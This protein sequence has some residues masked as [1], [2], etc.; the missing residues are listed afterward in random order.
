MRIQTRLK[1]DWSLPIARAILGLSIVFCL[2]GYAPATDTKSKAKSPDAGTNL[3]L[4]EFLDNHCLDCHS[5]GDEFSIEHF[6]ESP[7]VAGKLDGAGE[8]EQVLLK[9]TSR[10]MPPLDET[11]RPTELEYD[12]VTKALRGLLA[13]H[14]RLSPR[15]GSTESLRRLTR[16]EYQNAVRDL[17]AV[18]IDATKLLPPDQ[19][20]GGFDNITVGDLS[21][22]RV[23]RLLAAAEKIS[24][25]AV[26]VVGSQPRSEVF[27]VPADVTQKAR[28]PGMPL[29]TRGGLIVDY[30][31]PRTGKYRVELRLARD[32]NEHVEGMRGEHRLEVLLDRKPTASFTVRPP[33]DGDHSQVD[34]GLTAEIDVEAGNRQLAVTFVDKGAALLETMRQPLQSRF[35]YHRHPRQNP[36]LYEVAI[37][38]PVGGEVPLAEEKSESR[39][40]I[41]AGIPVGDQRSRAANVFARLCRNAYRRPVNEKDLVRPLAFYDSAIESGGSFDEAIQAGLSCIL[42]SPHFLLRVERRANEEAGAQRITDLELASRLSFFLWSSLPDEQLLNLAE[43]NQLSQPEVLSKQVHRM[44]AD[45][46]S[47]SLTTNFA[48]QWLYLK[49]LSSFTPDA[50]RF[51]DFDENLRRAFRRETEL[52]F[53]WVV[54]E[55]RSV[56]DLF[57][58]DFTFLNE[59]LA[60]HY[61]IPGVYGSHFRRVSLTGDTLR[62]GLLRHASI[63]TITS[64]PTRTSPV[65]RGNWILKNLL[66]TPPPPPPED[67]PPLEDNTVSA[68]LPLRERLAAHR[69]NDACA[70]CHRLMDPI[71]FALENYDA[72]GRWREMEGRNPINTSGKLPDGSE[73]DGV[74]GL[75]AA[76][77]G[78]PEQFVETLTR[79]LATYAVGRPME[80]FDSPMIRQIVSDAEQA[81]YSFESL[82][83][84]IV[85]SDIFQMRGSG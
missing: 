9:L 35:N 23:T 79:K 34:A 25:L 27:R 33:A 44:L 74:G 57:A 38:G 69:D 64:Y 36:A 55:N 16:F 8:L 45:P 11:T 56:L 82:V 71:G 15:F 20:S 84:G 72:I 10:Q 31:F 75:Q 1:Y 68:D 13:E 48:A 50:R 30:T 61:A 43:A 22:S 18:H 28:L 2:A 51:P 21:P 81:E 39:L 62:G 73:F 76:L 37:T 58:T 83:Q 63:L 5:K 52:L 70:G 59:R 46:K 32:R 47:E 49:N 65:I 6:I 77:L 3:D 4:A 78:R 85:A 12:Q 26:G 60:K 7:L 19:S 67:V 41:F 80:Y 40:K 53:D 54:N 29:G 17:L 24:R 66:G 14:Q 42:V